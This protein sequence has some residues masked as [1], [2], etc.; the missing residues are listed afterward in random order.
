MNTYEGKNRFISTLLSCG[1]LFAAVA[2]LLLQSCSPFSARTL[3]LSS[4]SLA[5]L[6]PATDKIDPNCLSSKAYDACIFRKNPVA[7]QARAFNNE[8]TAS[9]V[10]SAQIYG[11]KLTGLDSS[12]KL[13]NESIYIETMSGK[14]LNTLSPM[15]LS[16]IQDEDRAS[17]QLMAYYWLNRTIE[18]VSAVT[19]QFYAKGKNIR[20]VVDDTVAGYS[21]LKN[22]IHVRRNEEGNEMAWNAELLVHFLGLANLH[23]A[24]EGEITN[25][26]SGS[27]NKHALCGQGVENGCCKTQDGCAAAIASGAA[28]YLAAIMFPTQPS[29][30]ETWTNKLEGLS[31]C[32]IP[33]DLSRNSNLTADEAYNACEKLEPKSLGEVHAMGSVYASVWWEVRKSVGLAGA[34]H[35][36]TLYMEHLALLDGKD[37]FNSALSKIKS[38]DTR[39]FGSRY[40]K[41]FV[42][43]FRSRGIN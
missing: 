41:E 15:R 1:T 17:A 38:V 7:D 6:Q 31:H 14:P 8:P 2:A 33:R 18:Y 29:F 12:G 9:E 24:T 27:S 30:G 43:Q 16:I 22:S 37:D 32:G 20:V 19:G 10:A 23:F 40:Y 13:K 4:R 42:N 36:D 39:L 5:V 11:V 34:P 35:I 21:S 28:D 25:Y 26:G 3:D